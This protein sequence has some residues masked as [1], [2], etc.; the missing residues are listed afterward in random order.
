MK[1]NHKF[2]KINIPSVSITL[3]FVDEAPLTSQRIRLFKWTSYD[4]IFQISLSHT[5]TEILD[6]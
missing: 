4:F 6:I 2:N 5:L 1:A 3:W